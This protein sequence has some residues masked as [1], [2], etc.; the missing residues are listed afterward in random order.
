MVKKNSNSSK[1]SYNKQIVKK[2]I[3]EKLRDNIKK[4]HSSLKNNKD[5]LERYLD[6]IE[7][8]CIFDHDYLPSIKIQDISTIFI[9]F[10]KS[11]VDDSSYKP[12]I[13]VKLI[14][15][16]MI[17]DTPID[18]YHPVQIME[19]L[20]SIDDKLKMCRILFNIK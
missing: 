15:G 4:L 2:F 9:F 10:P 18:Y 5:I 19:F 20:A 6:D 8:K 3:S 11:P 13:S 16:S 7:R 14:D 17:P 12:T 1:K